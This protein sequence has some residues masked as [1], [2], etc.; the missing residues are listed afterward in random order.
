[1]NK[2][3]RTAVAESH[4]DWGPG[5]V[6]SIGFLAL[7]VVLSEALVQ[8]WP[9][10]APALVN[11]L[12]YSLFCWITVFA[13][14]RWAAARGIA[15]E[16]FAFARPS[17]ADIVIALAAAAFGLFAIWP[18]SQLVARLFGLGVRGMSFDLRAPLVLP[19][20]VV[21]AIVTAPLCEE[22]L[23]RGLA[24][25]C[26]RARRWPA[27]AIVFASSTAFAAIHLPY[28]G[29]ALALFILMWSAMI[30]SIRLW[31]RNLTPG[32]MIHV[33]NNI[34]AYLVTPWLHFGQHP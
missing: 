24:V 20:V 12:G 30:C 32:W 29:V 23:F 4:P 27:S 9:S 13:L 26:L 19:G 17:W 7:P 5:G 28:F 22:I 11:W 25:A 18:A 15:A 33:L 1:M 34:V 14:W 3:G 31:R 16:I 21:W 6:W 2:I 8:S 10:Q